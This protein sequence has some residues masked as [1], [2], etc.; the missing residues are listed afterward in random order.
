MNY[1]IE[2]YRNGFTKAPGPEIFYLND[3]EK[4]YDL[5][6]YIYI[7]KGDNFLMIYDTGC[8]DIDIINE[9]LLKEFKGKITFDLPE[10]EKI[11]A[12]L[13]KANIDPLD[14]NYVFLSHLHHDHCSNVGLFKNA[15]VILSRNGWI[16][17]KMKNRPYFYNDIL[18]PKEP[19]KYIDSL[20]PEKTVYIDNGTEIAPGISAFWVGGHTP[21]C[22]AMIVN[23]SI[24]RAALTSDIAFLERNITED[25]PIGFF[26][27]LW[28]IYE[29]Y[30][31][32]RQNSD[33]VLTSHD[34]DILR[35]RFK[36]GIIK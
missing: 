1:E 15:K 10:D 18:Y 4:E 26:Y 22:A 6:T 21:C 11:E 35:K 9:M 14:V 5:F 23:T 2:I 3:W 33:F 30:K 32:I 34:P 28:E 27:N 36:E 25:K 31:K 8:G 17:Y 24:G 16:N 12:I 29:G 13:N 7:I 19:I 20:P